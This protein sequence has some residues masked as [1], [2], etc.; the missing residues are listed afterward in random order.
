MI[1]AMNTP[2][3]MIVAGSSIAM[4]KWGTG[5]KDPRLYYVTGCK[6]LLIP[7]ATALVFALLPL[8]SMLIMIPV[9]A[10]ACPVA[11]ACPM[12]SVMYDQDTDYASQLFAVTTIFSILT[13]PLIYLLAAALG[14]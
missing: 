14:I 2:F 8:D 3:A 5:L 6:N 7:A 12:L 1:G 10:V 9:F 11:A 13:I 4:T